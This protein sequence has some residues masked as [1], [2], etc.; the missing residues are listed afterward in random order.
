LLCGISY[1]IP[2]LT[3]ITQ[4][5][6]TR[7]SWSFEP[8]CRGGDSVELVSRRHFYSQLKRM[9][10]FGARKYDFL[11]TIFIWIQAS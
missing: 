4:P 1:L 6:S 2:P 9:H 10:H 11:H 5:Y 8:A 3:F 7:V